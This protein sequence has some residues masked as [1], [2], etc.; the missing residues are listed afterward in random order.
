MIKPS[1]LRYVGIVL[2]MI[3]LGISILTVLRGPSPYVF[4]TRVGLPE[5]STSPL[6]LP[7]IWPPRNVRIATSL[8]SREISILILDKHNYELFMETGNATLLRN[9]E[10]K[11]LLILKYR[12][13]E[14]IMLF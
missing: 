14:S 8:G 13:E 5:N 11:A 4:A 3:G 1:K 12:L 2:L 10:R 7:Q 6:F 9:L